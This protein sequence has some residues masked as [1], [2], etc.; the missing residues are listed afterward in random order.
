MS[1]AIM[2]H[3]DLPQDQ[4]IEVD[5]DAVPHY[6]RGGWQQVP[7]EEL[8]ERAARAA[9]ERVAA[10]AE[11]GES[12]PEHAA[13]DPETDQAQ[14]H[15]APE[16]EQ[17]EA[18]ETAETSDDASAATDAPESGDPANTRKRTARTRRAQTDEEN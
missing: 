7:A 2:R 6:V 11:E 16:P 9:A 15:P 8:A 5:R 1:A 12:D 17:A 10:A 14:E 3:P 18:P 13:A 4:E